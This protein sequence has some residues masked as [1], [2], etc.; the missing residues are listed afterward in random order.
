ML[1]AAALC[2][3]CAPGQL[4]GGPGSPVRLDTPDAVGWE[5]G[6]PFPIELTVYNASGHR[7]T[8]VQPQPDAI[9]VKVFRA[10]DGTLACRT[11]SPS[12]R[13]AEGWDAK[14]VLASQGLHVKVDLWPFCRNL[15]EG[16]Y[17]YELIYV[18]NPASASVAVFTGTLGPRNGRIAVGAGLSSDEAALA[19]ALALPASEQPASTSPSPPPATASAP[20]PAQ[21][22]ESVKA[23]L[24]R[25]LAARGLNAY[26][27]PEGT[28][29]PNGPPADEGGRVLY[30]AGRNPEIRA[31]CHVQ[32]F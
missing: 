24:D 13:T 7:L 19:G 10:S 18:A 15:A 31:A 32:G 26:G 17:R 16:L 30:V 6:G 4:D 23:C 2:L 25:E 5:P 29:Y 3:S 20:P 9:Q 12:R 21:S 14:N 8:L 28:T 22:A 1:L 11:P 27:D